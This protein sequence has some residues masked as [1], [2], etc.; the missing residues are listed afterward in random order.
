M[1]SRLITGSNRGIGLEHAVRYAGRGARVWAT[2]REPGAAE[3]L[4]ALAATHPG[5]VVVLAYDASA[6]SAAA[7]LKRQIGDA[8]LDL[9]FAN[10]GGMGG[11]RQ[12][13]G[14]VDTEAV[15]DLIQ[16]NAL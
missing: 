4:N 8:P 14:N 15:L 2:A 11:R 9:M 1:K 3:E 12:S 5:K 7:D 10:A 13:F 6:P 16:V